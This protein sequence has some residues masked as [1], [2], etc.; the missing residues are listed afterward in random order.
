MQIRLQRFLSQ[1]GIASRRQGEKLITDGKIKVNGRVI[2]ELGFKVDPEK[3]KVEFKGK[4]ALFQ[5]KIYLA[6][7]KPAGYLC[8]TSDNFNRS[9]VIDLVKDKSVK[10][11][12]VGRLDL[13]TEGLLILTNDG[14]FAFKLT[15]PRHHISK[16]YIAS[17]DRPLKEADRLKLEEGVLLEEGL[18]QPAKISNLAKNKIRITL[19]EGKKRQIKRMLA[20]SGYKVIHLKR[21]AIGSLKLGNLKTGTLRELKDF[22]VKSLLNLTKA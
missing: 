5:K 21:A 2:K 19:Y 13:D 18:T 6:L 3:D 1:S 10:L 17:L 11:F 8:T 12:P 20:L 7:N 16:V 9:T 22:E 14:D 4:A 15:H